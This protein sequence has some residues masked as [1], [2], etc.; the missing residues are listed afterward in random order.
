MAK[1]PLYA[2]LI[3]KTN[4]CNFVIARGWQS[5]ITKH[6]LCNMGLT[7]SDLDTLNIS[8]F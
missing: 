2:L 8:K 3:S 7:E 5:K 4:L 6:E 1:I